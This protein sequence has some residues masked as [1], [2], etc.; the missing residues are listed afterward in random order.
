MTLVKQPKIKLFSLIGS[1]AAP[2]PALCCSFPL[3]LMTCWTGGTEQD[4]P[5]KKTKKKNDDDFSIVPLQPPGWDSQRALLWSFIT[6]GQRRCSTPPWFVLSEE[7]EE[8]KEKEVE[9]GGRW[10]SPPICALTLKRL[11]VVSITTNQSAGWQPLQCSLEESCMCV[12]V[13][14]LGFFCAGGSRGCMGWSISIVNNSHICFPA[15]LWVTEE[16]PNRIH[17]MCVVVVRHLQYC[18]CSVFCVV[19]SPSVLLYGLRKLAW[20]SRGPRSS[21]CVRLFCNSYDSQFPKN[22]RLVNLN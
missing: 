20:K 9:K 10:V 1:T 7:E 11:T 18:V 13:I 21:G 4:D 12:C 5:A 22:C 8:E 2:S 15:S 19:S 3:R 17:I 16:K 6:A 14:C